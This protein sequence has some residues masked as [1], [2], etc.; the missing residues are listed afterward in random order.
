MDNVIQFPK[1]NS[2][3]QSPDANSLEMI[4]AVRQQFCDEVVSDVLDAVAGILSSYGIMSNGSP[5]SIKDIVFLEESL[6]ALTYRYKHLDHSLHS[7]IEQAIS[8]SPEIEQ[9][10]KE[11]YTENQDG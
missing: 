7:V 9:Q 6:K 5:E 4:Q 8:I 1:N 3:P 2:N 11:R 10:I